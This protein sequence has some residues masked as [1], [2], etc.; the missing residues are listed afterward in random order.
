VRLINE[1]STYI[2]KG[3]EFA[4]FDKIDSDDYVNQA[5]NS[6]KNDYNEI[7]KISLGDSTGTKN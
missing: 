3:R 4:F 7:L 1:A 5:I 2:L 6:L